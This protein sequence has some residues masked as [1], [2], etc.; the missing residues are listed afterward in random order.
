M[1]PVH[2][3]DTRV[4]VN[5]M[6]KMERRPV[7]RSAVASI[8]FDHEAGSLMSNAPK[9]DIANTTRRR[10]KIMLHV[11]D[12]ESAFSEL[13]PKIPVMSRPRATYIT[14]IESP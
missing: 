12:V 14:M 8:L 3:K 7:V 11:A 2:E 5:A 1:G 9:N 13:A 6:K 10:K 4:N